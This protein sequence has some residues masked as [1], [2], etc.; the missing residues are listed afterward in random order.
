MAGSSQAARAAERAALLQQKRKTTDL[1]RARFARF[2]DDVLSIVLGFALKPKSL[3]ILLGKL[4]MK[5]TG[6]LESD[7]NAVWTFIAQSG[8]AEFLK[9]VRGYKIKQVDAAEIDRLL[10]ED[11]LEALRNDRTAPAPDET[12]PLPNAAAAA[13]ALPGWDGV[14]RRSGSDRRS[15]RDRRDDISAIK[16]NRRYGGDRRDKRRR[17]R[18]KSDT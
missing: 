7:L 13:R 10:D 4:E 1:V 8:S 15:G 3:P 12:Q 17:G 2:G 9:K 6:Q 18:R 16:K 5:P 11:D 14:E